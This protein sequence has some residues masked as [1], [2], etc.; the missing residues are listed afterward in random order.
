[1]AFL[2]R[3]ATARSSA[4]R[5][6]RDSGVTSAGSKSSAGRWS[7]SSATRRSQPR[8]ARSAWT[9][10]SFTNW[11]ERSTRSSA[12]GRLRVLHVRCEPPCPRGND[13]EARDQAAAS[14]SSSTTA[15][16]STHDKACATSSTASRRP[17]AVRDGGVL[18]QLDYRPTDEREEMEW[19]LFSPAGI[20]EA[21]LRSAA[22]TNAR[23]P[24]CRGWCT[25][26]SGDK[27]L[28]KARVR[29]ALSPSRASG[30]SR[31][32]RA[33]STSDS[34]RAPSRASAPSRPA[35]SRGST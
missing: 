19:E 27:S 5:L 15:R 21:S 32:L 24:T 12:C 30:A 16:S 23:H 20:T 31:T 8:P 7:A 35:Q 14:S 2:R 18:V 22:S 34:R 6:L 3:V 4:R 25:S 17:S 10:A 26:S 9:C 33:A 29:A 13:R 1:M 11:M 28:F